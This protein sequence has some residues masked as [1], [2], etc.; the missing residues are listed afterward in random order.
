LILRKPALLAVT[1]LAMIDGPSSAQG[2][3]AMSFHI[4]W[5]SGWA[6]CPRG[7]DR[8]LAAPEARCA[9]SC[10]GETLVSHHTSSSWVVVSVA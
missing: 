8:W 2:P 1:V 9:F 7:P 6:G 3:R 5:P 4:A 10:P